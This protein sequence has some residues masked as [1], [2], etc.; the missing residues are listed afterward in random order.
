MSITT[1][2]KVVLGCPVG[3]DSFITSV[4]SAKISDWM[5]QIIRCA[6]IAV[7][8]PHAAYYAFGIGVF[9]KWTYLCRVFPFSEGDL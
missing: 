6:E 1:E 3:T 9:G 5:D 8:E 2:R 4:V 7:T